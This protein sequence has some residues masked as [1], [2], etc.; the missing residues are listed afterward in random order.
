MVVL[1]QI[2]IEDYDYWI[3]LNNDP[4][5]LHFMESD[6]EFDNED[7]RAILSSDLVKWYLIKELNDELEYYN[8]G[9]FTVYVRNSELYLGIIIDKNYRRQGFARKA[10]MDYLKYMDEAG[11]ATN[12]CYFTDNFAA[13]LYESLGYIHTGE[14][15]VVRGREFIYARREANGNK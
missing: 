15:K 12:L 2:S 7:F 14:K 3:E 8:V 11:I 4:E 13:K 9:L 1:Q 6:R 5:N 10:F